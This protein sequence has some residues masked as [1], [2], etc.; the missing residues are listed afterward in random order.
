[1]IAAYDAQFTQHA[2]A[3]AA[4]AE[5]APATQAQTANQ[6]QLPS[7]QSASPKPTDEPKVEGEQP[8]TDEAKKGDQPKNLGDLFASGDLV[9][10]FNAEAVPDTVVSAFKAAGLDDA[11]IAAMHAQFRAG[12][13]ALQREHASNLHQAAG[14]KA[15]FDA[16]V[17]W[18][19]KNLSQ[20]QRQFYDEQLNGPNAAE[21]I[22]VLA[23]RMTAGQDPKVVLAN[24]SAAPAVTGFRDKTE[25]MAA[26]SDPRYKTSEAYRQDVRVKLAASRF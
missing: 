10:G 21:A 24:T 22:A 19:Q 18:G 16:L 14:G 7:D 20:E 15:Q 4:Q 8:K 3:P 17:A 25:M 23:Q 6:Q 5:V 26:M 1:M 9:A 12:Q 13:Q 2:P 11:A